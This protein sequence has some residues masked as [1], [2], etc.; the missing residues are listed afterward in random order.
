[1]PFIN[2]FVR[3]SLEQPAIYVTIILLALLSVLPLFTSDIYILGVLVLANLYAIFSASWDILSGYTGK[4]NFGHALFI[5]AGAYAAAYLNLKLGIPPYLNLIFGGLVGVIFGLLLGIPCLRL[6]GPY[7]ALATMAAA[8]IAEKLINHFS[9][10]TGGEEGLYGLDPITQG[11]VA[12][13]YFSLLLLALTLLV[14]MSIG[15]SRYGIILRSIGSDETA[16]EASG[17]NTT[18]YKLAAFMISAFFAGV[19]GAF[20][21]HYQMF[22]GPSYLGIIT[23]ITILIMC[24]VGGLRTVIGPVLGAYLLTILNEV[25]RSAGDFRLLLYTGLVVVIVLFL[26]R[27]IFNTMLDHLP[28]MK[29]RSEA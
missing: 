4:E 13:Y 27:G 7:L 1:M 18:F 8:T 2:K 22:A 10:I 23:S 6:K 24:I 29:K 26:P 25:L 15:Y 28:R 3:F 19:A 5:G 9:S 16:A 11:P 17:I 21:A 20:Y 14:L 12:D